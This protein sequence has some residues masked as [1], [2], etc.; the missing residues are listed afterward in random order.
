MISL[1]A[2]RQPLRKPGQDNCSSYW[3]SVYIKIV[4]SLQKWYMSSINNPLCGNLNQTIRRNS[5]SYGFIFRLFMNRFVFEC[6]LYQ[7]SISTSCWINSKAIVACHARDQVPCV[8]MP[9]KISIFKV[10]YTSI[11]CI[12]CVSHYIRELRRFS[13]S[14]IVSVK[15]GFFESLSNR[16]LFVDWQRLWFADYND[17]V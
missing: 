14:D 15:S 17:L 2:Y 13:S 8:S 1:E 6:S 3:A 5:H 16:N 12:I 7:Y 4:C 10:L 9:H 11:D